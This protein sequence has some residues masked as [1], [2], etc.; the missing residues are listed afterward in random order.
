MKAEQNQ[1]TQNFKTP[2]AKDKKATGWGTYKEEGRNYRAGAGK[3]NWEGPKKPKGFVRG[4]QWLA[5]MTLR[6]S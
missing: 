3:G 4:T 2:P 6:P 1:I 5:V